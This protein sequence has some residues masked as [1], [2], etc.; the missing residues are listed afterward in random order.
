MSDPKLIFVTMDGVRWDEFFAGSVHNPGNQKYMTNFWEKHARR[1]EVFGG[2]KERE[3]FLASHPSLISLPCYQTIFTGE[4]GAGNDNHGGIVESMTWLDHVVHA[5]K[6]SPT[7]VGVFGSWSKI[8]R[9]V[10]CRPETIT[11]NTGL[12]RFDQGPEYVA[13]SNDQLKDLPPW[14]DCRWDRYTIK[15]AETFLRQKQPKVLYV[16]L[17]DA[18]DAA[19]TEKFDD[20]TGA[21]RRFDTWLDELI[22]FVEADP[23]YSKDTHLV[24]STDHG[25]G[26]GKDWIDHRADLPHAKYIWLAYR[27]IGTENPGSLSGVSEHSDL[28]RSFTSMMTS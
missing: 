14:G 28:A 20:Y 5:R 9:A 26:E 4:L 8:D 23:Y 1:F 16:S 17:T 12:N 15:M 24:L 6:F 22:G 18:D 10:S 11:V 2:D 13:I 25:R 3:P 27:H 7:D 21:I 19:H